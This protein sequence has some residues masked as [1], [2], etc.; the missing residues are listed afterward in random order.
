MLIGSYLEATEGWKFVK[1][2]RGFPFPGEDICRY[3][4]DTDKM[5]G[6]WQVGGNRFCPAVEKI[7]TGAKI[8]STVYNI[9]I[10]TDHDDTTMNELIKSVQWE[11]INTSHEQF[12][13]LREI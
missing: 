11:K 2:P 5:L 6:I 10:V 3:R 12:G 4:K 1:I 8:D 9:A 13:R 7:V